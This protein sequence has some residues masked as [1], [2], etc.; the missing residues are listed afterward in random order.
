MD[1][2]DVEG[3]RRTLAA[4]GIC[5][6]F[7]ISG[8]AGGGGGDAATTA[9]ST[10]STTATTAPALQSLSAGYRQARWQSGVITTFIGDCTLQLTTTGTPSHGQAAYY[11]VPPNL[12]AGTSG[13]VVATTPIGRLQLV[14]AT[15]PVVTASRTYTFNICPQRAVN[16]S[17]TRGGATGW[18][19]TGAALFN[20][21][22]GD[23]TTVAVADNVTIQ[24]TPPGGAAQTAGFLDT[25]AGHQAPGN[26]YHYHG[27]SPCVSTAAGDTDTGPSR[28]AGIALDG[29]PIYGDRDINGNTVPVSALDECNGITSPTPEFPNGIYHYVLPRN[30]A[31]AQAAPRCYRG[32]VPP[33]LLAAIVMQGGVCGPPATSVA[34]RNRIGSSITL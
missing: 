21:F 11:L 16:T 28:L 20:A 29:Y 4:A 33:E 30:N 18:M 17:N 34:A 6:A 32:T 26:Q 22:E 2:F 19:V 5:L 3:A 14:V 13:P 24:Y 12:F 1:R 25:C 9:A 8:C 15:L 10:T 31:T 7:G 27:Y 23:G